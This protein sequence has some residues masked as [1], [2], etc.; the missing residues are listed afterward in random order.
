MQRLQKATQQ[1]TRQHNRELVLKVIQANQHTSRAEIARFTQLTRTTVSEVVAG[2]MIEGLVEEIG[3]GSSQGGKPSIRLQMAADSRYLVGV[4]LSQEKF[5]G[6]LVNLR[7]ELKETVE[8]PVIDTGSSQALSQL[9]QLI[10]RLLA[11]TRR[12]VVGIGVGAPGLINTQEGVVVHAVNLDWRSFPLARLLK[13]RYHLPVSIMN[14]SQATAI[15]EYV[16]GKHAVTGNLV[17][18]NVNQGIGA[19]I[20]IQGRLFQ[21]DGGYAG[22]IGHI[23][24]PGNRRACRCGRTGCLET[25]AGVQAVLQS[26]QERSPGPPWSLD[27]LVECAAGADP[28]A[29][30]VVAEAGQALG[31]ALSHL[32]GALNIQS[33]I[34]TGGL[35]RFGQ[36][37]LAAVQQGLHQSTLP[38]LAADTRISFGALDLRACILGASAHLLLENYGLLFLKPET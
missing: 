6:A 20:I 7:G 12:P 35:V 31:V 1:N 4:N 14:D 33:I 25:I 3:P 36:P 29:Q 22:E 10:D 2:L 5:S 37:W 24:V 18:V 15:G 16:Y 26:M 27:S 11:N 38:R 21:G 32:A 17:V 34:L 23:G 9:C 13:E 19:G 8:L 28:I 30:A